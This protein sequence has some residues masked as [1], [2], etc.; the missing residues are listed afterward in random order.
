MS[1]LKWPLCSPK[2]LGPELVFSFGLSSLECCP[3]LSG[4][5]QLLIMSA[6]Q[7]AGRRRRDRQY[8]CHYLKGMSQK[9]I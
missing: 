8:T 6:F 7:S 4:T 5:R 9:L 1:E 2:S 3:H